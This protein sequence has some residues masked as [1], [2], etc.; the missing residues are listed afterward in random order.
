VLRVNLIHIP[1]EF[2]LIL[3]TCITSYLDLLPN[4]ALVV[5][6]TCL[7]KKKVETC[8]AR[9]GNT[10]KSHRTEQDRALLGTTRR[11]RGTNVR[12][13]LRNDVMMFPISM[14][15]IRDKVTALH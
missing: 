14:C 12:Y 9:T 6:I 4:L 5:G 8:S 3:N 10:D 2:N 15:D 1:S 11:G 13:K 7:T